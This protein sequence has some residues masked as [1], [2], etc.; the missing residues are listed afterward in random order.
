MYKT[1]ILHYNH[2]FLS[3]SLTFYLHLQ[4]KCFPTIYICTLFWALDIRNHANFNLMYKSILFMNELC[5]KN[6]TSMTTFK[7]ELYKNK[8]H[9]IEFSNSILSIL[10]TS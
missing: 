6:L 9:K 7:K 8:S 3:I 5:S 4:T 1:F 10:T 2:S